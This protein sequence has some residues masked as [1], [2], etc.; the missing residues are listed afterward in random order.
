MIAERSSRRRP[1]LDGTDDRR[2]NGTRDAATGHLA[3]DAADIRRRGR[4]GQQRN[5]HA[6]DLSAHAATHRTCDG[7]SKRTEIDIPGRAR[8]NISADGAADELYDQIDEKSRRD[9]ILPGSG[10]QFASSRAPDHRHTAQLKRL[11][12]EGHA[13]PAKDWKEKC[14]IASAI[15]AA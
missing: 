11:Y 1:V 9:A 6:E 13:A 2:E 15:S 5:Q 4:I 8:G 3:D 14:K 7:V 10:V 12:G